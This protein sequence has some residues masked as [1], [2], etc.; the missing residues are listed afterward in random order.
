MSLTLSTLIFDLDGTLIDSKPGVVKSFV[1]AAK[2]VF[3]EIALDKS[4]VPV[5]PPIRQ[6]CQAVFPNIAE[7]EMERMAAAF[8]VHYD[9]QGWTNTELYDG[10]GDV[11]S[12]CKQNGLMLDIATNKPLG[13]TKAVLSHLKIDGFFRSVVAVD[14]ITP[15]FAGKTEIIRHLIKLNRMD[16]ERT[17]YVGDTAEDAEAARACGIRFVWAAYGYGRMKGGEQILATINKLAELGEFLYK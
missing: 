13:V 12:K 17:V 16:L 14:S 2:T 5:G 8:R 7:P 9:S 11:L 3:P 15:P 10:A 6:I 1:L 4:L